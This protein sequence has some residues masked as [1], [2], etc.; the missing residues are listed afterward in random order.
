MLG[1]QWAPPK[2]KPIRKLPFIP[3]EQEIDQLIAACNKKTSTFLQLLKETGARCGEAWQ[4]KW[5]GI[6]SENK[7]VSITPEKGSEP[8][9]LKISDKLSSMLNSLPKNQ[10]E[11][12]EG[13]L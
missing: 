9:M 8:R 4:L 7:T 1:G 13:S 6:N 2:Y 10:P 12:F 3:T 11:T 5:T